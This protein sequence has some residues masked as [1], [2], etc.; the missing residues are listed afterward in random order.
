M[1]ARCNKSFPFH[2]DFPE[3]RHSRVPQRAR[4]A[5][6]GK[7]K[8]ALP[9]KKGKKLQKSPSE[10]GGVRVVA[11]G[12]T[13]ISA[14]GT[15]QHLGPLGADTPEQRTP[16]RSGIIGLAGA[17]LRGPPSRGVA[18]QLTPQNRALDLLQDM[19]RRVESIERYVGFMIT[20]LGRW[21]EL[22][23]QAGS[24]VALNPTTD[25]HHGGWKN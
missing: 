7:G 19:R 22:V 16:A 6:D 9:S 8:K 5:G 17:M 13:V 18:H 25:H 15:E 20:H 24:A 23:A 2:A 3:S 12:I 10:R 14:D 11:T 1:I 4:N 21:V